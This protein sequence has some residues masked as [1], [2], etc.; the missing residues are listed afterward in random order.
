VSSVISD[1]FLRGRSI[2]AA[3]APNDKAFIIFVALKGLGAAANTPS[4]IGLFVAHFPPG[5]RRNK[6]FGILGAGQPLGFILGLVLGISSLA[7]L[8]ILTPHI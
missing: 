2:G 3:L 8:I 6:A 5:P 7:N 1:M 4:G